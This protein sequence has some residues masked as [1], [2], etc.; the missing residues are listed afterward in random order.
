MIIIK[1]SLIQILIFAIITEFVADMKIP[2]FETKQSWD[3]VEVRPKAHMFYW[4]YHTTHSS[5]FKNRPLIMWLQV[6]RLKGER[7]GPPMV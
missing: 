4:L 2:S 3:Y 7:Y 5:G 6:S 1:L